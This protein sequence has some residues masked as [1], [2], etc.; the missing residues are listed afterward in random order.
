[1]LAVLPL[2]ALASG[3]HE[4]GEAFAQARGAL[5]LA[6]LIAAAA[7]GEALRQAEK[8]APLREAAALRA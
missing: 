2:A 1:M 7:A 3:L 8:R 4:V 5:E 6:W